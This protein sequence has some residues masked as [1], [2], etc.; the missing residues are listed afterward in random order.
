MADSFAARVRL[1]AGGAC[2]Y[3]RL[4]EAALAADF[5]IDHIVARKHGGQTR[6]SNL[7]W[8]CFHRNVY[9]GTNLTGIDPRSGKLTP[10]FHPRRHRW[11]A[12]FHWDGSVLVGRTAIGRTTIH[13]LNMNDEL[14][15]RLRRELIA[16]DELPHG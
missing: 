8:A 10:L 1:R 16:G 9:K 13:V 5:H 7:A 15:V 11:S 6:M 2:E 14:L 12:H 3:C 4:P